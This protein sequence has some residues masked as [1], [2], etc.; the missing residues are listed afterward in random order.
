MRKVLLT[1]ICIATV[2]ALSSCGGKGKKADK[3]EV[4][5]DKV[6]E[7]IEKATF[8]GDKN[9]KEAAAFW[10][11]KNFGIKL[12]DVTP[13]FEFGNEAGKYDFLG[14]EN[15][16]SYVT[17][18]AK[19]STLN[20]EDFIEFV[21][22]V[23]NTTAKTADGGINVYGF[24]AKSDPAEA[25]A[26]KTLEVVLDEGKPSKIFG[27]EIYMGTYGWNFIK[28]GIYYMVDV[29]Q[30]EKKVNGE[31][32]PYAARVII[33]KG[34][35]KNLDE[36]MKEVEKALEDPEVQKQMEKALKDLSK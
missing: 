14:E 5:L 16:S 30:L 22:K 31:D 20:R 17:F 28:D 23:Y 25:A 6:V 4:D 15:S 24:I 13:E 29:K 2:A 12:A 1:I 11:K 35:Q 36:S 18:T 27:I 3:G 33:G 19:D 26:E 21:K 9:T 34:L 7:N 32:H 8:D 10:F